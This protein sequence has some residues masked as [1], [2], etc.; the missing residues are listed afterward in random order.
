MSG[1]INSRLENSFDRGRNCDGLE[2]IES[3]DLDTSIQLPME[4]IKA[5]KLR[6]RK[7]IDGAYQNIYIF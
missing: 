4:Q 6:I 5:H 3:K 7:F 2:E 1:A